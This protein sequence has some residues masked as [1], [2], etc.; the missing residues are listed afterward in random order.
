MCTSTW[1]ISSMFQDIKCQNVLLILFLIGYYIKH[2][3]CT[4]KFNISLK[5][6]RAITSPANLPLISLSRFKRWYNVV[7][8]DAIIDYPHYLNFYVDKKWQG[9]FKFSTISKFPIILAYWI[10]QNAYS[11]TIKTIPWSQLYGKL[12][13]AKILRY[14]AHLSITY[15][16]KKLD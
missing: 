6:S 16:L 4:L 2:C 1:N 15:L 12:Y 11:S 13:Q 7:L 5:N 8:W 9:L 14:I 3:S 10:N